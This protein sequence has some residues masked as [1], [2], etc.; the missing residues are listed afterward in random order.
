MTVLALVS[1]RSRR[2]RHSSLAAIKL[3]PVPRRVP[4]EAA[5]R[6]AAV[7]RGRPR[8]NSSRALAAQSPDLSSE[9]HRDGG[10]QEAAG[11]AR[12]AGFIQPSKSPF[13]APILFVKKKDGTMR[14]CVDYRALNNITIKNSYPLPR[15]DELFDR[16]Q[17]AK[18]FSKIDLRSGYH[19]IRIDRRGRAQDRVPHALRSLRVPRAA[20][21][22]DQRARHLHAPDAPDLPRVP[23]RLRPRVPRRHPHLQQ[24]AGGARA[25]RAPGAGDAAQAR[26]CTPRRASASSSRPRSSSSVTSSAATACA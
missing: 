5:G 3:S 14:M 16:L 1:V 15:V 25:T 20:V 11:G 2:T 26:S 12:A 10:A 23:R 6:P 17:G 21:R 9:R 18:Y 8:S 19:Q 7:A 22:P 13:G 4:R 24:D